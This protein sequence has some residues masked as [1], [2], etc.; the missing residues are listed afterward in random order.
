L[1]SAIHESSR[2]GVVSTA[3]YRYLCIVG[4][5]RAQIATTVDNAKYLD[6]FAIRI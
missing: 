6:A 3:N 1:W 5:Y 4:E 2:P